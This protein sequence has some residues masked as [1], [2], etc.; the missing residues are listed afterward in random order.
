M[1]AASSGEDAEGKRLTATATSA[2]SAAHAYLLALP[3]P[4]P[5]SSH[6]MPWAD[7]PWAGSNYWSRQAAMLAAGSEDAEGGQHTSPSHPSP[8]PL[9]LSHSLD[10]T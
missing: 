6:P 9:S 1:L 7:G 2:R 8:S 4:F 10:P 3:I 5:P